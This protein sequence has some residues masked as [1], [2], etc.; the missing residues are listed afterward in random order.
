[1]EKCKYKI[2]VG[3][4]TLQLEDEVNKLWEKGMRP[5][6][7][8]AVFLRHPNSNN[9]PIFYIQAMVD[10]SDM[11]E[12]EFLTTSYSATSE[13]GGCCYSSIPI[14]PSPPTMSCEQPIFIIPQRKNGKANIE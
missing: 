6:G 2:V 12:G 3:N 14:V 11:I 8:V 10:K 1:M 5:Q 7:G 9:P 4:T 13:V